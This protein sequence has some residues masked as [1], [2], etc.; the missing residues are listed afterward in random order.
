MGPTGHSLWDPRVGCGEAEAP[1]ALL[2]TDTRIHEARWSTACTRSV[3]TGD[4]GLWHSATGHGGQEARALIKW[5][6]ARGILRMAFL[7]GLPSQFPCMA[8]R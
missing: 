7:I 5:L 6:G 2:L 1:P 8:N 3:C 4:R